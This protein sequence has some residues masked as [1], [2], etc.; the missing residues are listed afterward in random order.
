M[1]V[2]LFDIDGT[3]IDSDGAGG[4]ALRRALA[5][6]FALLDG[7]DRV[8]FD[9]KTDPQI[10]REILSWHGSERIFSAEEI[11]SLFSVYLSFLREELSAGD[12]FRVLP[13]VRELVGLLDRNGDFLVG[14]ATGNIQEGAQLKLDRAGLGSFFPFG[15]FGSD[16]EDR[17]ELT[18]TA[19]KRAHERAD[20]EVERIFI[21]G[22]TPR[23]IVHGKEAGATTVAVASGNYS[24]ES[25]EGY[26]P[27]LVLKSLAPIEPV[28]DFLTA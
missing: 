26:K 21:I 7:T 18:R 9:G 5:Q 17:T 28:V 19:V 20:E 12:G 16:S 11:T 15:G 13:G 8:R 24:L 10:V 1:R 23:D 2:V 14:L 27:D 3:L 22:D 25:L 6:Q 4:R